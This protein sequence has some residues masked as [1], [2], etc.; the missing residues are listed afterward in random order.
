MS[1]LFNQ[2]QTDLKTALKAREELKLSTL[3][4]LFSAIKYKKIELKKEPED[5]DIQKVVKTLVKQRQDSVA[6]YRQGKRED[7]AQKEEA[8]IEILKAYLP[9]EM[10]ESELEK[11][12]AETLKEVDASTSADL[13]KAMGAVMK[14]VAGRADGNNVRLMVTKKLSG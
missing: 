2:I 12:V 5:A 8:E 6:S 3:R 4:M 11:I 9:A 1:N 14:K 13:G 10:P 7:L